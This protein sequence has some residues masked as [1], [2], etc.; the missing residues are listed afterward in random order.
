MQRV[1]EMQESGIFDLKMLIYG[2]PK[3]GKSH[4]CG[5]YTKGPVYVYTF[6]EGGAKTYRK[7][8]HSDKIMVA[9]YMEPDRNKAASWKD[10]IKDLQQA[11][12]DGFFE[13]AQA[14]NALVVFESTTTM[15]DAIMRLVIYKNHKSI[16][17][18]DSIPHQATQPQWG[19]GV[20]IM[21]EF[22]N[23]VTTLPCAVAVT[24]HTRTE[25]DEV[26]GKLIGFPTTV[27]KT[28]GPQQAMHFD[29]LIYIAM[30]AG[31]HT[32]HLK[33]TGIYQAGTRTILP[34]SVVDLTMDDMFNAYIH[35]RQPQQS[36]GK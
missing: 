16:F 30:S 31:R 33:G 5:T 32:F 20:R 25:K 24:A 21:Q 34:K 27:G 8:P 3:T 10:F 1:S 26:S 2:E 29:D 11:G 17:D 6:D 14:D 36:K 4:F 18:A 7:M 35:K 13:Q 9:Q 12:K 28:Y 22:I 15:A 23:T 19:S